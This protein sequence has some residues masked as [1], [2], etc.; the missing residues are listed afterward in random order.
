MRPSRRP[1]TEAASLTEVLRWQAADRPESLS[2]R[3]LADGEC[4]TETLTYMALDRGARAIGALLQDLNAAGE[5]VLLLYGAGLE[6][7]SAFFGCLYAGAVAV[8][9]YPPRPHRPFERIRAIVADSGATIALTTREL[10][11]ALE[12][13]IAEQPDLARLAWRTTDDLGREAA[14]WRD[15]G[16]GAETL[17][18]LQYTSGSTAAPKGV[19]VTHGNLLHNE[20]L[21]AAVCEHDASTPCVSWLPLYHDLGLIGNLIQSLCV[22]A[23]CTL[24]SPLSFLQS[25]LRWLRAVSRYSAHTS[26]GPNFAYELCVAR[27]T[28]EQLQGLD[29][30]SWKVAFNGA[31]PVRRETLERFVATFEPYGFPR[32][33]LLPCYGLAETT[34]IVSA[35]GR[36]RP[37]AHARFRAEGL[38]LHRVEEAA[39]DDAAARHLVGCGSVLG[40]QEVRIV[41]PETLAVCPAGRV[42]EIWVSGPSVARGYWGRRDETAATFG[43]PLSGRGSFLRTGDLGF[44][45]NGELYIAG[46][47]KDLI[48][49]RGANHYPQDIE[50]TVERSHPALR[51]GG[52][53]AFSVEIAGEEG[54]V[55]VQE[56]ERT[57][58]RLDVAEVAAAVRQ[59]VASEHELQLHALALI[60]PRTLPRTTSGKVRR[61]KTKA[62]FLGGTL[63]LLGEWREGGGEA[64]VETA[65]VP[66][67][68]QGSRAGLERWLAERLAGLVGGTFA[69]DLPLTEVGLDSLQAAELAWGI[70]QRSG[71]RVPIESLLGGLTLSELI[72]LTAA[73]PPP[74]GDAATEPPEDEGP[75]PWEREEEAAGPAGDHPLSAGQRALWFLY[76]LEPES[77]AYHIATAASVDGAIDGAA[78]HRA[79]QA[80]V[81]RHPMLRTSFVVK[82]GEPWQREHPAVAVDFA[83]EDLSGLDEEQRRERLRAA[84]SEPFDLGRGSLLRVRLYDS[85]PQPILLIVVHHIASDLWSMA[86]VARDLGAFYRGEVLGGGAPRRRFTEHVRWQSRRL[87]GRESVRALDWWRAQLAGEPPVLDLPTD[88]PRPPVQTYRGDAAGLRLDA[89]FAAQVRALA[90]RERTTL[91]MT[92]LAAYQALLHRFSGQSELLVG[93]P[94]AGAGRERFSDVVGYFVNLL[95]LRADLVAAPSFAALLQ[96]ARRNVLTAAAHDYP[97]PL[98]VEHLRPQRDASRAPLVQTMLALQSA[99]AIG[100]TDLAAF[101]VG[102]EGAEIDI[103][104]LRLRLLPPPVRSAQLDLG[105]SLAESSGGL[106][107]M[108]DFNADLFDPVTAKRLAR[109]FETL[110]A[111][112]A[113]DPA[114]RVA[115]LP[116]LSPGERAQLLAEWS[117]GSTL[118][119]PAADGALVHELFAVLA[120]RQPEA[121]AVVHGGSRMTYGE[122]AARSAAFAARLRGLG[123]GPEELVGLCADRGFDLV[124]GVLAIL[125]AGAGYVPLDPAAP[126][127]RLARQLAGAGVRILLCERHLDRGWPEGIVTVELGACDPGSSANPSAVPVSPANAACLIYTSG[128][129]GEPKGVLIEHRSLVCLTAS[130]VHSYAPGPADAILPLTSVAS[131]SLVG[132]LLPALATGAA[133]V[134]PDPEQLLDPERLTALIAECGVTILSTVPSLVA[135]LNTWHDRLA[136]LRLILS[137]GE[138]LTGGDVDRLL[139]RVVVVNGY[140]LTE[141]GVCST[142][143]RLTAADL[144]STTPISIG[145]PVPGHRVYV[146]DAGLELRPMNCP[147]ELFIA[148]EGLSRGYQGGPAA[149][150]ERFLPDPFAAGERMYRTGD[151]ARWLSDGR[152]EYLGRGDE[153]VKIRGYRVELGEIEAVL[154]RHGAVRECAVLARCDRGERRLCAYYVCREG[155]SATAGELLAYLKERLPDYMIPADFVR[156]PALPLTANGKLDHAALPLPE[157]IRPELAS[158]FVAARSEVEQRIAAVWREV[159]GID[160]VGVQDNFF[161]LGGHSLLLARAQAR[162]QDALAAEGLAGVE[163]PSL[164]DLFRYPTI[165]ALAGFLSQGGERR[166]TPRPARRRSDREDIAIIA[167]SGRFP[168]A[169]SVPE[170][171]RNLL[172]EVES[173]TRFSVEEL[174]AEGVDDELLA[175]PS[176]V[177]AK[178]ILGDVELFD[179]AFFGYSPRGAELTDPQHRVFLECA[180]EALE[181]AGYDAD[182]Y[183]G[184][185]GVFA[186]QS[187]NT[188]WLSNLYHH[189]DLVASVDSLQAAIGND[190]DSLTTE[191]SY[192]LNLRGPSVLVQSSSSTSLT[193]VHYAC[194]SLLADE[195][196]MALA[197]GASIHVPERSGYLYSE[198]GTTDPDGHCRAFDAAAKGFVSGH[199][200]GI[201]VLKR[202]SAALADGDR[203]LAV[204][205]GSA[206]N[207]DGAL[208]VSY[209]A[210]SVDGHAEVVRLAQEAAGVDPDTITYVEAHGTGTPLGDPIE[211]TALTQAFRAATDR[212]Q[213]CALGTIK[214][215]IGHLDTA[216]GVAGLIKT[217]LCLHNR[218][219]PPILHFTRPNPQIDFANSPF[220]VNAELCRWEVP[221]GMP[222]RAG[223][224]SLGMGGTNTHVVLEEA[225]SAEPSGP[226]REWQL[227][228]FSTRSETALATLTDRLMARLRQEAELVLADAAWTLQIGRKAFQHRRAVVCRSGEEAADALAAHDP[229]RVVEGICR[230]GERSVA[231][232]LSGQ[233][234]QY[235]GMGRGLYA[236]EE[237]FRRELDRCAEILIPRLGADLRALLYGG[238]EGEPGYADHELQQTAVAQPALFAVEYALAQLW[239]SWGVRPQA[240]CGHSVGELVAACLAGVF[241]LPDALA[242]VAERGRLM[243]SLPAGAMLAVP[244]LEPEVEP[245]LAHFPAV[246]LAAIPQPR[247]CVV[248]GPSDAVA[249]M[250]RELAA[251][252]LDG[253]PLHTSHAFHS[254]MMEPILPAFSAAVAAV[255]REAPRVP[256]LS[257]VTGTWA[258]AEEVTDPAYWARQIR[259]TVRFADEVGELLRDAGRVFLEVGPGD[260]LATAARQHPARSGQPVISSLRHPK[261]TEADTAFLAGAIGR[262]WVA[263]VAIDFT[264][265]HQG[266]R[267]CRVALPTY[268]FERRRY[269]VDPKRPSG[270]E[271][272][273]RRKPEEWL[274]VPVWKQ[275]SRPGTPASGVAGVAGE[276]WLLFVD[277]AGLGWKLAVRLSDL[278]AEVATVE[279]GER[280]ERTGR[281]SFR[282]D[283]RKDGDPIALLKELWDEGWRP[284][285]IVHLWTFTGQ[286]ET[287]GTSTALDRGFHTV[288]AL[289]SALGNRGDRSSVD[290]LVVSSGVQAVTGEETLE[291]ARAT[292]LGV[293]GVIRRELPGVSCRA[294]DLVGGSPSAPVP[295]HLL[296]GLIAE[297]TSSLE[298]VAAW[299]G[300]HRWVQIWE[301][302]QDEGTGGPRLKRDGVYLITGGLGGIGLALAEHLAVRW[303]ARIVLVGRSEL[304]VQGE[305]KSW[306]ADY[307]EDD[308]T[309]RRIRKLQRLAELGTDALVVVADCC[310]RAAIEAV[311]AQA[312]ARFGRIDGVFHAAGVPGMGLIQTKTRE[313]TERVLAPKVRGTEVLGDLF[314][315][316]VDFLVL[317][318]SV[319]S[320]HPQPGQ[321]DY[322]A[323]NAFLDCWAHAGSARGSAFTVAINWDAWQELGMAVETAVPEEVQDY[324]EESL[325]QGLA[326]D[327]AL[328]ALERVLAGSWPQ[329]AIS[330]QDVQSEIERL[331]SAPDL[332]ELV[333]GLVRRDGHARPTLANTYVPPR[334]AVE[335][336]I[337]AAWQEILRVEQIG[338]ND[339]FFELGGNSLIGVKVVS[340]LKAEFPE[341]SISQAALFE[342]PTVAAMA[343]L[344][345]REQDDVE[346]MGSEAMTERL[347]RGALRRER[348]RERRKAQN[349]GPS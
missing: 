309:S 23:T 141:T 108:L 63:S 264:A 11:A 247:L 157:A 72:D 259:G 276:K 207:N 348:L 331:V 196:N 87:A 318:S 184:R 74:A 258:R 125:R 39:P 335:Q 246:A 46:R 170:L 105:L 330:R 291:P 286:G 185:I 178:G 193:A 210:P 13:R 132:E 221:P 78:L 64:P 336:R 166:A 202:L 299:R 30:A 130:F 54:L 204:I 171:W 31:E 287:L 112:A 34:L 159:L 1:L 139:E 197:G 84:A 35:G 129:T 89:A 349:E 93:S 91:F 310:D 229:E 100:G 307:G 52:G 312:L 268:P 249:A 134:L 303:N 95:V 7:V 113:A 86:V 194:Q 77:A 278:G 58:R 190:K 344:L 328:A 110:L 301:T 288:L 222:R 212:K 37:Y 334:D 341:A 181:L 98:L 24:M 121:V 48:I 187:M 156:L 99:P 285:R 295:A 3:F 154:G 142:I 198:G 226:S 5:R 271:G 122:L 323:A 218:T 231:F 200:V 28:P 176:Y 269:W 47:L 253:R 4:E 83:R 32:E 127:E 227:L 82:D 270:G 57:R 62:D 327:R 342:A 158:T 92:L 172:D 68:G 317:F 248:S 203:I 73:F 69:P 236:S 186:G 145:I 66:D 107:G 21:I 277:G 9:V 234:A 293:C 191:V 209:T 85:M 118:A 53:A 6:Y 316:L 163:A 161:D 136:G 267:R 22:G 192:R 256:L 29:L 153:Q 314:G 42:G 223:V 116:I 151:L 97:F 179:A 332:E 43:T 230:G 235:A 199:G 243:Q 216:A 160:R 162:L 280:Y 254:A 18:F 174:S 302:P 115:D 206:C 325:R 104:P 281:R 313:A 300:R 252:G 51:P 242:L 152:L 180:W 88:R 167:M 294:V 201:V 308:R 148:G 19:M 257:N 297:A 232:L 339:N 213:Y 56:V 283:P 79:L 321:S 188:Y 111:A 238:P 81:D 214:T 144:S 169:R 275:S 45:W 164:I 255:R 12:A 131:A 119:D 114:R 189:I 27:S 155:W 173:I 49:V 175:N 225:P 183:P 326:P 61:A 217:A 251:A 343:R 241:T 109:A 102:E 8:P 208:K 296:D 25:P 128:S 15:P 347:D 338:T 245:W 240:L 38:A 319:T 67:P 265:Y 220:F 150:A 224:S 239:M 90:R 215:N 261:Q 20:R 16:A 260:T 195:C 14:A 304:P 106:V 80:L 289:A 340:R 273:A 76:L 2:L 211:I 306:L 177:R 40:D 60:K 298:A 26:G 322:A 101:A 59:A 147:G 135:S 71:R 311:K 219:I 205:K 282:L 324:R 290:L 41:D 36:S 320:I 233:G 65:S 149:T 146:L 263:G 17:A 272:R 292:V 133:V 333:D 244:L 182:R 228:P 345:R 168:G 279:P 337:A 143:H 329:V 96:Q 237:V 50:L 140:G 55:V 274:Q 315:D 266:E 70:E 126:G 137:G 124:V 120:A 103:G 305:W 250:G 165:S 117:T 33:A 94:S 262:L 10:H 123:A 44:F 346:G 75:E 138:A 284:R